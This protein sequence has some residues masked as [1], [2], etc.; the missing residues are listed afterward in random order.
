M[1]G[2][3]SGDRELLATC[4]SSLLN[5]EMHNAFADIVRFDVLHMLIETT[6]LLLGLFTV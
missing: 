1:T 2:G 6:S 4:I 3:E 5:L